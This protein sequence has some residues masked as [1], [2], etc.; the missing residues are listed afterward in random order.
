M[1]ASAQIRSEKVFGKFCTIALLTSTALLASA[2][3]D[4]IGKTPAYWCT[5][6]G[7]VGQ[8]GASTLKVNSWAML[9]YKDVRNGVKAGCPN[10]SQC[11][12]PDWNPYIALNMGVDFAAACPNWPARRETSALFSL[13]HPSCG[14]RNGCANT[15]DSSPA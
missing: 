7:Q 12:V 8:H 4:E 6:N 10:G 14:I 9:S 3:V 11:F 2:A 5:F 1:T 15:T 13:T